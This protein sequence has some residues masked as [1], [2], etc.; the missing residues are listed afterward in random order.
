LKAVFENHFPQVGKTIDRDASALV[1]KTALELEA[2]IKQEMTAP[3]HGRTYRRRGRSHTAAA[4]GEAPGVDTGGLVNS[5]ETVMDGDFAAEVG[6]P[7][8]YA[9]I[10][11]KDHPAFADAGKKAEK[12]FE[13]NVRRLR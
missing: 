5:I 12:I 2:V 1:K 7:K 11:E 13:R 10:L 3:K 8:E 4:R 9:P 6:T